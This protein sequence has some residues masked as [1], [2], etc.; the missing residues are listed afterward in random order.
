MW[1]KI[2]LALIGGAV[3]AMS[4]EFIMLL[5][6]HAS[7]GFPTEIF[8]ANILASFLLGW[9]TS[10][11]R[12]KRVSDE[13][14]HLLGTGIMGG[15]STFSSFAYGAFSEMTT[16]G[17]MLVSLAYIGASLITGYIAIWLGMKIARK[18]K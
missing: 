6:P 12:L 10:Y 8:V 18:E 15:M 14:I 2:I 5:V 16:P 13:F 17:G 1:V 4:R 7:D 11:H 3:G 9:A